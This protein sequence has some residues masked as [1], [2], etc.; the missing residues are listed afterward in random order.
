[1][2]IARMLPDRR[3][4]V[5]R[6]GDG[7]V[8]VWSGD[9]ADPDGLLISTKAAMDVGLDCLRIASLIEN[10][11]VA[12]LAASIELK[13]PTEVTEDHAARIVLTAEGAPIAIDL[14]AAQF[15]EL[16]AAFAALAR[17]IG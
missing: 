8:L 4:R 15:V 1:M 10:Q 7:E 3:P 5:E 11:P 9:D 12:L 17:E 14:G 6:Y 13:V 2:V 16:A